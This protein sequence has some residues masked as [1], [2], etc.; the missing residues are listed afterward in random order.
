[1]IKKIAKTI[2][3]TTVAAY[4][5]LNIWVGRI[6]AAPTTGGVAGGALEAKGTDQPTDLFGASGIFTQV[7]N[8]LLFGVGI[9]SVIMLIYGGF[10]YI[11][12]GGDSKRVTDAKNTIMYAIIGLIIAIL[13][14]AIIN[15]I[16]TSLASSSTG[17]QLN[18]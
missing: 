6:F 1:M 4:A 11:I 13:S 17:A 9:I 18:V 14:Y 15:F 7:T 12:S 3:A 8:T 2:L 5:T 16:I 10:R